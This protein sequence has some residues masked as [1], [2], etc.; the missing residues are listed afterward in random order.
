MDFAENNDQ[1]SIHNVF[2]HR[3]KEICHVF[4]RFL[5]FKSRE[6]SFICDL[7]YRIMCIILNIIIIRVLF[8]HDVCQ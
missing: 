2:S 7:M 4:Q 6:R 8:S 3:F 5:L 1:K